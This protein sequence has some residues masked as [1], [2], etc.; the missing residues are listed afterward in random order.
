M[1][2]KTL[3]PSFASD[4]LKL[5]TGTAIAQIIT[6]L[7]Y[8][9]LTR[10]YGPAAFGLFALF[11]SI[12][13]IIGVIA[14]LRYELAIMLP[15]RDEEAANI[16]GIC[17]ILVIIISLSLFPIIYF[18]GDFFVNIINAP[19]LA[20]YLWLLPIFILVNGIFL[21]LNY[22]TLRR[23]LFNRLSFT[24]VT[25]TLTTTVSQLS[26]GFTGY[27]TGGSLIFGSLLGSIVSTGILGGQFFRDERS[28]CKKNV[29][30]NGIKIALKRYKK[31]PLIESG[32]ALMNVL[33]WQL[34]V[35]LLS[36]FFSTTIVGYYSLGFS[37]LQ[38]PMNVIGG[39]LTQVFFQGAVKA[40]SDGQL[41]FI[42]GNFFIILVLIGIFPL[43]VISLLGSDLFSLIFG[44]VWA[45]AGFYA[46]ILSLWGFVWFISSPLS[47]VWLVLEKQEFGAKINFFNLITRFGALII[48]G[49]C[50]SPVIALILFATSGIIVYGY[51][52]FKI[53]LF[54]KVELKSVINNLFNTIWIVIPLILIIV[55]L[56]WLN[57]EL[58]IEFFIICIL[59]GIYYL[60]IFKKNKFLNEMVSPLKDLQGRFF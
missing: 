40:H 35:L 54:S 42:V 51:L 53:L 43:I 21:A 17:F 44:E 58:S 32:S 8:P 6:I 12:T 38:M 2:G 11:I 22:W 27:T 23:T 60:Y 52:V 45:E 49:L 46:Q 24:R 55:G 30:W 13:A 9:I 15:E 19:D 1:S 34:P 37:V 59:G 4:I 36:I 57:I 28:T 33:S 7:A 39:A 20:H 5:I 14:C 56:M 31:F 47:S 16:L 50:K 25:S 41:H 29:S 48:G 26:T 3:T 10:I 18:L